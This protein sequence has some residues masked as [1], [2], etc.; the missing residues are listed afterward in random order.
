MTFSVLGFRLINAL[1]YLHI[2]DTGA[3]FVWTSTLND[4]FARFKFF[5]RIKQKRQAI[6]N[7]PDAIIRGLIPCP[8]FGKQ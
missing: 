5:I 4:Q 6:K 8:G 2:D 1:R 3:R 7:R